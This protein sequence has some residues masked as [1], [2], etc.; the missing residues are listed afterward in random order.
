MEKEQ[1]IKTQTLQATVD[2]QG[3]PE[4]RSGHRSCATSNHLL[5]YGGYNKRSDSDE[6]F[7]EILCY[8]ITTK[9]W[10]EISY[11]SHMRLESASCSMLLYYDKLIIFGGS[12]FPFGHA[13]SNDLS[14]YCLSTKKWN[15]IVGKDGNHD[16]PV[17]KYGHSMA[18]SKKE[19]RLYVFSGTTGR[20]FTDEMHYFNLLDNSWHQM[21]CTDNRP[22]S[23]YRHEIVFND[24]YFYVFGGGTKTE[25]FGL[26]TISRFSFT[27]HQWEDVHCKSSD[28]GAYPPA[29]LHHSC[30]LYKDIVYMCGGL[31]YDDEYNVQCL[32]DIWKLDLH[33]FT[34]S[35]ANIKLPRPVYFHSAAVSPEGCM[36]IFGG[37]IALHP[38]QR[39]SDLHEIWLDVPPLLKLCLNYVIQRIGYKTNNLYEILTMLGIP[40]RLLDR[41]FM[42]VP[43]G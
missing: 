21:K 14:T 18:L 17:P 31:T 30:I 2:C 23:R 40:P 28:N 22:T 39:T 19:G 26:D 42:D 12:G 11:S 9:K 10:E 34:W 27:T 13:N 8:N 1:A 38:Q 43:F 36:L 20:T 4:V 32:D 15:K 35:S 6:V 24:D 37:V 5:V 29:R 7:S 41:M 16:V 25:L 3:V 33:N